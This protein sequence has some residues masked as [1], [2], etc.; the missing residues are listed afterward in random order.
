[1]TQTSPLVRVALY[2]RV[3]HEKDD[4]SKSVDDQLAELRRWAERE[5][6]TIVSVHRD[7]GISASRYAKGKARPGWQEAME[8][9]TDRRVDAVLV[10]EISRASRDRPVF[11]ALFAACAD[12]EVLIG[13]NGRLHDLNDADDAF[14]LDLGA[15]LA[16]RE[17][18]M[19]AKRVQRSI[20]ARALEGRPHGTV[21]YGYKRVLSPETGRT[22]AREI[23]E[24]EAAIV[25]EVVARLLTREPADSVAADLNQRGVPTPSG[26][27]WIGGNLSRM[28]RRPAYAGLR[29][30]QGKVLGDVRGT[31]PVL[32]SEA[33]HHHL[34][35]MFTDPGRDKFRNP[36]VARHLGSG[37][38]RCGREG[39]DGRMRVA[40]MASGTKRY[41]CRECHR[42]C[43][44]QDPTDDLIQ[45][46]LIARLSQPDVLA[47]LDEGDDTETTEAAAE[48]AR[49]KLKL[50]DA[51]AA[52]EDDRLSL[53]SFTDMEARMLPR[54][55][56]AEERARPR[57]LPPVLFEVAGPD[58]KAR[59]H[60]LPI[61]D[62][63]A[64]LA[65]L[66]DVTILP[67]EKHSNDFDPQLIRVD[68]RGE[69]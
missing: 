43:R 65:A 57:H 20:N 9:I 45:K 41:D 28:A 19:I 56:A 61:G 32:I 13:T 51:R 37:I 69:K 54:I 27:R 24:D 38:F 46:L 2:G 68:W 34:L 26:G 8:D 16:V 63:R 59:W 52:W 36:K 18:A 53:E 64:V 62:R 25:R 3:S 35:A 40:T 17:S 55:R 30:H 10:W 29:V 15:A 31:W 1:M 11:A 66:M 58:A 14:A 42:V 12:A 49:L 67:L 5:G 60:A 7:D 33:D 47:L 50:R 23:H 48:V 44:R 22:I 21:P 39:C 6:W 4:Q